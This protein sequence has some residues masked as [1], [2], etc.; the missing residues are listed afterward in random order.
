MGMNENK[1]KSDAYL[2]L[3][4]LRVGIID[5]LP[6]GALMVENLEKSLSEAG[7]LYKTVPHS[8]D[9]ISSLKDFTPELILIVPQ[10]PYSQDLEFLKKIRRSADYIN[11]PCLFFLADKQT[12]EEASCL[13]LKAEGLIIAPLSD[14]DLIVTLRTRILRARAIKSQMTHDS[15]SGVLN[16]NALIEQLETEIARAKRD[17]EML[18]FVMLDIDHFK[19]INDTY[20]HLMGDA[21]LKKLA[22]LLKERLRKSDCIGRYGGDEFALIL[23]KTQ[24]VAAAQ[25]LSQINF[26]FSKVFEDISEID[27]IPTLSAGVTQLSNALSAEALIHSADSAL[28]QAKHQGRN[29]IIISPKL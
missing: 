24:A 26:L 7:V 23:P 12:M 1:F 28:Y 16:H 2:G 9:I 20:G 22:S 6:T 15:L 11:V 21:I 27:I 13:A 8:P 14:N 4:P 5:C 3:Q 25:L 18:S 10:K 19:D 17:K 29:Q